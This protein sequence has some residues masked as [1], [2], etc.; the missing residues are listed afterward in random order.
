MSDCTSPSARLDP[1]PSTRLLR[2]GP[3]RTPFGETA[4]ALFMT[5]GF[6]YE[7]AE[8]ASARFAGEA[9]GYMYSRYDNPTVD[10]FEQRMAL[11][12]GAEK[13]A[14]TASGMAAM[15]ASLLCHLTQG[16][17]VVAG[18]ALFGSCRVVIEQILPR[19]G[20]THTLV[21]GTDLDA[22]R[23]AVRPE[24]KAFFLE[25]PSNP[26]L[27]IIDLAAVADIAHGAGGRLIVD[28]VFATPVLQRPM[29]LG[30]DVVFYSATKHVD[31]Q[32]RCLGGIVLSS[33][34]FYRDHLQ[35]FLR[36]TGPSMSPFNAWV[37]A[38]GLETLSLRVDRQSEHA[39]RVAE[40][41]TGR[42]GITRV[43]YP[44]RTDHPQH[45]LA[46]RQMRAGGTLLAFEVA[47]GTP[48]AFRMMNRLQ[49]ID[50]SNNLGDTKSLITH[51]ATTTHRKLSQQDR[52]VLG[53]SDGVLR[54][55][56]GLEDP[57]DLIDDLTQALSGARS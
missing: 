24:T 36:N 29:D 23:G 19:F 56:V 54:L 14:A 38:K 20:I 46:S 15:T 50:I 30:A 5:S 12:E 48:A 55:S 33:E 7:T 13:G 16:D 21:D 42:A 31:G 47:G 53:I 1:T 32:G 25:T 35:S 49:I 27:E 37:L 44:G 18:R 41:L 10:M 8:E 34:D 45:A 2:C 52:D 40:G 22:W 9:D 6:V 43:L 3:A 28:N 26:T 39:A 51:P 57:Q 17:H 11:L 4:E